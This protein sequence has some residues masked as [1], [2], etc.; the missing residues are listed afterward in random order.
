M[1]EHPKTLVAAVAEK[2][3]TPTAVAAAVAE[4]LKTLVAA[5]AERPK[6]PGLAVAEHPKTLVAAVAEKPKT[7]MA[8]VA[9]KP[10]RAPGTPH[11]PE[12][13]AAHTRPER[14]ILTRPK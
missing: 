1:A 5:V 3:K 7:P 9:E 6:T 4:H 14:T 12:P 2:R 11:K 10:K 8:A 13:G